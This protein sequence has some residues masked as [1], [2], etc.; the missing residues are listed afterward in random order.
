M[1]HLVATG[2]L[3]TRTG[4]GTVVASL[5]AASEAERTHLLGHEIE[6][7]AVEA[8]KLGIRLEDV[9]A[10]LSAHWKRLGEPEGPAQDSAPRGKGK[11]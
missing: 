2:L 8:K 1:T 3:E 11:R 6:Q 7:L 9:V 10:C 5:P 4:I